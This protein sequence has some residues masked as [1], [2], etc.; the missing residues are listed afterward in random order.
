MWLSSKLCG[1]NIPPLMNVDGHEQVR[2]FEMDEPRPSG[3]S[4]IRNCEDANVTN[5]TNRVNS[6]GVGG[7]IFHFNLQNGFDWTVA[8]P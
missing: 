6:I 1:C 5:T 3:I 2:W 7:I 8:H 4:R